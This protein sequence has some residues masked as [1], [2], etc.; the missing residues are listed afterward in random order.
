MRFIRSSYRLIAVALSFSATALLAAELTIGYQTG[1]QPSV[2]AQAQGEFEKNTQATLHW[3]RF[4]TGADLVKALASG[5]VQIGYLGVSPF[6]AAISR[7]VPLQAILVA[8]L[9]GDAEALVVRPEIQ[10]PED[11]VGKKIAVPFVSTSHYGLLK[12]L[13]L[14]G[15]EPRTLRLLNM[16]PPSIVA[17]WQRGDIDGAFVWD[18]ALGVAKQTGQVLL[19]AADLA[20]N[21]SPVLDVWVVR[22]AFAQAYPQA[23]TDFTDT[24]LQSYA[25]YRENTAQ[26]LDD[27]QQLQL[28]SRVSGAK[29]SDIAQLLAGNQFP[30]RAEQAALL[31]QTLPKAMADTADFLHAQGQLTKRLADYSAYITTDFVVELQEQ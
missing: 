23:V 24:V 1:V 15:V 2:L 27:P 18:P 17:A 29:S 21:Q 28:I 3:Q 31:T 7:D 13:E 12:A 9:L 30:V 16:D 8:E 20:A 5:Q 25:N 14:W 19:S 22:Q 11:L 26:F 4:N 10:Q 6:T